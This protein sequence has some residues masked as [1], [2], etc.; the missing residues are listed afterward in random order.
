MQ[1]YLFTHHREVIS[2]KCWLKFKKENKK[3][4]DR[5]GIYKGIYPEKY[6]LVVFGLN[7]VVF[8]GDECL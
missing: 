2:W 3:Y 6:D 4:S 7:N 5:G 8:N 1:T